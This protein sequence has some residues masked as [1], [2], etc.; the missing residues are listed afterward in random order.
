[1]KVLRVTFAYIRNKDKL[2][3]KDPLGAEPWLGS[4]ETY[5]EWMMWML[6]WFRVV[7][8]PSDSPGD[9]ESPSDFD[10]ED[11]PNK[12]PSDEIVVSKDPEE[13]KRKLKAGSNMIE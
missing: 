6:T 9:C 10:C 7:S 3:L 13:R 2:Y 1:M 12:L 8:R 5:C 4:A 11:D